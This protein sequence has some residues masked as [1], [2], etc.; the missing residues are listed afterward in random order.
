MASPRGVEPPTFGFVGRRSIQLSYGLVESESSIRDLGPPTS[1]S[2]PLFEPA[3]WNHPD[4]SAV[5][6]STASV[7]AR[8]V[9]RT[10]CG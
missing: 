6:P 1:P 9:A 3:A 7:I 2:G 8:I 4:A 10:D 5:N